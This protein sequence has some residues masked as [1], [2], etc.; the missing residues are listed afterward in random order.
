[1]VKIKNL[2]KNKKLV[3]LFIVLIII[4]LI[5]SLFMNKKSDAYKEVIDAIKGKST[6]IVYIGSG[7][8]EKCLSC[9]DAI[10]VLDEYE[11]K[12]VKYDLDI[13]KAR[14]YKKLL[15]KM[16]INYNKFKSPGIIY[17]NNG[18]VVSYISDISDEET[19]REFVRIH[20]LKPQ[21]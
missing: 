15:R 16:K 9:K 7:N 14:E 6:I 1:M 5:L 10:N 20:Q 19:V 12:Y 13:Y 8:T 3:V 11:M 21:W 17:I 18:K 2:F 4:V